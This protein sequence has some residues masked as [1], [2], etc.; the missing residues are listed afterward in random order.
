MF[1][2]ESRLK[3]LSGAVLE[4]SSRSGKTWSSVDNIVLLA[5]K[6]E[7]DATINIIKETY[8][9]FKTSLYEDF[10][11]RLPDFGIPSPFAGKKE[12][13]SFFLLGSR[14]NLLG[15]DSETVMHGVG[16]DYF[17]I[18]EALDVSQNVFDQ[19]EQRCRKFW[20]MDYN[21]KLTDHWIYNKVV[22]RSDVGFLKTTF[23]D[24]PYI[25]PAEKRKILSYEP[26]HPEDRHLPVEE[27]RKHP[28]NIKEGTADSYM[29]NV[30][31]LGMRCAPE[32]VIFDVEWVS[33]MPKDL[34]KY[35]WGSDIGQTNSP[36][37]VVRSGV[38]RIAKPGESKPNLYLECLAYQPTPSPNDYVN[39]LAGIEGLGHVWADSAVP[40]Y[41]SACQKARM[42]VNGVRKGRILDG[43]ARMKN[44][45]IKLVRNG[46]YHEVNKEA[47]N[48]KYREIYGIKTND[49]IDDFN[50]FWDASRYSVIANL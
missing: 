43:I 48:Y 31:G 35:C 41:I 6:V 28:T 16:S 29:W 26:T 1:L 42:K 44:Y 4:G 25:S 32:G 8:N 39:L 18:N 13:S 9:S 49:P 47:N 7:T 10:D 15:A 45:R 11:R 30:Y 38:D 21:P 34:I 3:G 37:V 33:E 40:E 12:V 14:V 2:A 20:W 23:L 46:F 36:S 17:Y 19:L 22:T 50:H 27:R 24:N 5:S